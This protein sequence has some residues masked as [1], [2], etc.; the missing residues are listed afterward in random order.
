MILPFLLAGLLAAG[1]ALA[2][3]NPL[4]KVYFGETH[5]HTGWSFDAYI[6][7]NRRTGPA[8]AY[9]YA[10]GKPIKHPVGYTIRLKHP[11]DWVAVTDHS[12]YSGTVRL[13]NEP[14]CRTA[15]AITLIR[16]AS[17][18]G[19]IP[20]TPGPLTGK[21]TFSAAKV[22]KTGHPRSVCRA[23]AWPAWLFYR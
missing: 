1:P 6:F 14:G 4:C 11:L 2:G 7:G 16:S 22:P 10:L 5:V 17:W 19:P 21:K 13:A 3:K 8:E 23:A 18:A 12:E 20:M 15:G 9:E